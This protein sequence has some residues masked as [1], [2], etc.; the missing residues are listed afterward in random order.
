M[1][2]GFSNLEI[3]EIH[4]QIYRKTCHEDSDTV[5]ETLNTEKTEPSNQMETP[6]KSKR[7][8]QTQRNKH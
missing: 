7:N 8:T 1:K 2:D 6:S 4:Q 5:T 3:L